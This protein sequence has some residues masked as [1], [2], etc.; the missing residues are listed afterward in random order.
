[1]SS[2]V[3]SGSAS[4]PPVRGQASVIW[5]NPIAVCLNGCLIKC[6]ALPFYQCVANTAGSSNGFTFTDDECSLDWESSHCLPQ[7]L[8]KLMKVQELSAPLRPN[9]VGR[10]CCWSHRTQNQ[11]DGAANDL[12]ICLLP[13]GTLS[14]LQFC[15]C[16]NKLLSFGESVSSQLLPDL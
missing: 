4:D 5:K 11:D 12:R 10:Q 7:A 1:M 15:R 9:N 2:F 16:L 6:V 8:A 14:I 13:R 3:S